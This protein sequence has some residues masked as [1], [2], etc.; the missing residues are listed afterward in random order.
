ML[1]AIK[2]YDQFSLGTIEINDILSYRLLPVELMT[3]QLLAPDA[4]PQPSLSIG[5]V[6][7][8]LLGKLFELF[9]IGQHTRILKSPSISLF[10]RGR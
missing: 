1:P 8:E 6:F 9:V 5:H 10:Q 2:L 7:S 3:V 4:G